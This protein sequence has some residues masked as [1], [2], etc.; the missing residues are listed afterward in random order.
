MHFIDIKYFLKKFKKKS[1]KYSLTY[2]YNNTNVKV[3]A[4][5]TPLKT[6]IEKNSSYCM[7]M[8]NLNI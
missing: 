6:Y 2:F 1:S 4:K 8:E 7:N 3:G 5:L